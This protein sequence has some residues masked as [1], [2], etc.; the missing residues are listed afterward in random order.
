V[1]VGSS[2]VP[3]RVDFDDAPLQS[4]LGALPKT[5]LVAGIAASLELFADQREQG[6]LTEATFAADAGV[7]A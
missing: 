5:S 4:L 1:G 6:V 3:G 2:S 7:K